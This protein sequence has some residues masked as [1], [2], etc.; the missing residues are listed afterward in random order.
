MITEAISEECGIA[1]T[2]EEEETLS[3]DTEKVSV[4]VVDVKIDGSASDFDDTFVG[5]DVFEIGI[6]APVFVIPLLL[7]VIVIETTTVRDDVD[8]NNS[9]V[10]VLI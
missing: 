2:L 3:A 1:A 5:F 8:C 10:L 6:E 4:V 9:A 7:D